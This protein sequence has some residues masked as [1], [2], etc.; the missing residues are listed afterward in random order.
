MRDP[1]FVDTIVKFGNLHM[2]GFR[3]LH[4]R[5]RRCTTSRL[6]RR[7]IRSSAAVVTLRYTECTAVYL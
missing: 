4:M 6:V 2:K 5:Y 3:S 1:F 7:C